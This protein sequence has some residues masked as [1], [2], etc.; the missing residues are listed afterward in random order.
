MTLRDQILNKEILFMS[1][2]NIEGISEYQDDGCKLQGSVSRS[3]LIFMVL[4]LH[5]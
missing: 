5:V 4:L 1:V 3:T 2:A